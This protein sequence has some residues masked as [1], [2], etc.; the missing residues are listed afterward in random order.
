MGTYIALAQIR[1]DHELWVQ[2]GICIVDWASGL[3][4][5][6]SKQS[7]FDNCT[8]LAFKGNVRDFVTVLLIGPKQL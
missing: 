6:F 5:T 1:R 4:G 8:K 7:G 3:S 2:K